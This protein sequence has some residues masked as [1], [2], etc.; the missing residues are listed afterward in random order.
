MR[1]TPQK[2]RVAWGQTAFVSPDG[3]VDGNDAFSPEYEFR[4]AD[5]AGEGGDPLTADSPFAG[6]LG[7]APVRTAEL[8][9]SF[10]KF[11]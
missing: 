1:Y 7:L 8:L 10:S 3:W 11:F 4:S 5:P 9:I 6:S 2:E